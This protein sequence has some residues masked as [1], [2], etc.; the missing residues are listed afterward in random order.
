MKIF[1]L[2]AAMPALTDRKLLFVAANMSK[3]RLHVNDE[4][5]QFGFRLSEGLSQ[6]KFALILGIS[7]QSLCDIEKGRRIS[8][9]SRFRF[10]LQ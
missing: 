9:V 10:E 4:S 5:V 7:T 3:W 8:S 6:K 2:N 1:F